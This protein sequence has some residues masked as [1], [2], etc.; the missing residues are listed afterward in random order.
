M[1]LERSNSKVLILKPNIQ[2]IVGKRVWGPREHVSMEK[3]VL[4]T[5]VYSGAA[6]IMM[7]KV[8]KK[9]AKFL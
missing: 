7:L 2:V 6:I 9:N 4:K 8:R 5:V 1:G 3:K